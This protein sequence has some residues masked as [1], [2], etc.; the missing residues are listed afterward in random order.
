VTFGSPIVNISSPWPAGSTPTYTCQIV[1]PYGVGIPASAFSSLT[2]S[3]VD[4]LSGAIINGASQV[5]I[6]NTGRGMIDSSGN[7]TIVLETG[8]TSMS[9]A[10]GQAQIQ[11]A[12]V[13]D[14]TYATT[15]SQPSFGT[16]RHQVNFILLA[17][18]GP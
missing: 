16:S 13:I 4:T 7:L 6:L 15:G 1:D 11:R 18:A 9:E 10:P 3:I 5:N 8:D 17:L 2:L 14:W 12:L